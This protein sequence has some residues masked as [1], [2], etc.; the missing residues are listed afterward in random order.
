MN[1]LDSP[2]RW[3]GPKGVNGLQIEGPFRAHQ[4]SLKMLRDL[5]L[6]D[7]RDCACEV[8]QPGAP[9]SGDTR[10][11]GPFL[12]DVATFNDAQRNF[13]VFG[14]DVTMSNGLGAMFEVTERQWD[15]ATKPTDEFLA[16]TG[17]VMEMLGEHQCEGCLECY[18][19]TGRHGTFNC[20]E[21]FIHSIDSMFSQHAKWLT[22]AAHIP[23]RRNIA[24][25]Y[26]LRSRQYVNLVI[27][28]KHPAPQWLTM[29]AAVKHC[30]KGLGIWAW[31]NN[32]SMEAPDGVMACCGDVPT[33]ETLA[34]VSILREHLPEIKIRVVNVV[35]LMR[36][37]SE[38]E[39]PHGL[40]DRDFDELFTRDK[41][42]IFACH[43][44]PWL[45]HRPAYR[46]ANHD[47]IH[48]RGYK[49]EGTITTPFDTT[50]PNDL[51]RFHL[52]MDVIDRLPQTGDKGLALKRR[53]EEKQMEHRQYIRLHGRD[54][55][56]IRNW[57]WTP[58]T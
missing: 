46:R 10:V 43:G 33:L 23:W 7:F 27:A 25:L 40:R 32:D 14:A 45:M 18:L 20:H 35:D 17:R 11:L 30:T 13:R 3:T 42:V 15:A 16:P 19:L 41:P 29:D 48:L 31:A 58:A 56:E 55:P 39:H 4:V 6:P 53:L 38:T 21:A 2:K 37:Q 9:G 24:S 34:A 12:R 22:V 49:E 8:P 28:G 51:D 26:C 44:C 36:L 50:V 57:C 5:R 54:V 47:N 52:A 1:V